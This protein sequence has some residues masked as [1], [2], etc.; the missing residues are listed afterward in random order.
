MVSYER[1]LQLP[2]QSSNM[3]IILDQCKQKSLLLN[4][5]GKTRKKRH[6]MLPGLPRPE[7]NCHSSVSTPN[8][9]I[10]F[11]PWSS[12]LKTDI[13][14]SFDMS[15]ETPLITHEVPRWLF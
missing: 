14:G 12:Y 10:L 4:R 15:M 7:P 3:I 13:A 9:N 2:V 11:L 1:Y 5:L 8:P 6:P